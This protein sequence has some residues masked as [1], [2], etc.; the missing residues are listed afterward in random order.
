MKRF[1]VDPAGQTDPEQVRPAITI[2][3]DGARWIRSRFKGMLAYTSQLDLK[4]GTRWRTA[5]S[6]G[7]SSSK[8]VSALLPIRPGHSGV[9]IDFDRIACCNTRH[10]TI[11][12][13]TLLPE[14]FRPAASAGTPGTTYGWRR[15]GLWCTTACA[16]GTHASRAATCRI[17]SASTTRRCWRRYSGG[18]FRH[19][20]PQARTAALPRSPGQPYA[21]ALPPTCL[22]RPGRQAVDQDPL[23]GL[24]VSSDRRGSNSP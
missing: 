3:K 1:A 2:S 17:S 20:Q 7:G 13:Y 12:D 11:L 8:N 5:P 19:R 22:L 21:T 10:Q 18:D 24:L 14:P 4:Y 23:E 6:C 16:C 15:P 9:N